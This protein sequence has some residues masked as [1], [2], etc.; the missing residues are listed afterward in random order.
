[1]WSLIDQLVQQGVTDFFL[2]SGSRSTP[3]VL[4][5]AHHKKARIHRHFDERGLAFYALGAALAKE[6]PVAIIATSGTAIG[7]LLPAVMEAHHASAPLIL[8]TADR[9]AELRETC[10]NQTTDQV[11]MFQPFVR[12]QFD[13]EPSMPEMAIRSQAAHAVFRAMSGPVHLNC[14]LR[15]PLYPFET[16]AEGRKI[17]LHLGTL[18]AQQQRKL[19][20]RGVIFLGR[21]PKRSD[22]SAVLAL[23]HRLQWPVCA[24]I[25]SNARLTPTEEQLRAF[26]WLEPSPLDCILHFGER[27]TSKRLLNWKATEYIHVSPHTSWFDPAQQLTERF[28]SDIP[29]ACALFDA[30][31]D[32]TWL[33]R[34][35]EL[36]RELTN[37]IAPLFVPGSESSFF[38]SLSN[39]PLRGWNF[40][41]GTSMPVREADWFFHPPHGRAFFSN[42]GLSGIDGNIATAA[43]LAQTAPVLAL[44]GDLTALHDLNSLSLLKSSPHPIVLLI[45]N[46]G[47]GGIFSHLAISRDPRFE[48][49]FAFQHNFTFAGAAHMFGLPYE[50]DIQTAIEKKHSCIIEWTN[51]RAD[52]HRFHALLNSL[53]RAS[54]THG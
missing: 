2:A 10:A 38:H 45:S 29:A 48:E 44:V 9:P 3:L 39:L 11:K 50:R 42:R 41:L 8:L 22:L 4:A 52:N 17:P 13:F 33:P 40:F 26:H 16:G 12:W 24:D 35:K 15:E 43:G 7:N 27:M 51:S 46:N 34:W 25:L 28:H 36:D 49:L 20:S 14:P 6:A 18:S 32:S 53:I 47:G 19:P 21:L 30:E 54:Y 31:P 1:M 5:A 37:R 23:A